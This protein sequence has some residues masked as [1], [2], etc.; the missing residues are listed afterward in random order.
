MIESRPDVLR[1]PRALLRPGADG[2]AAV[3]VWANG[4]RVERSVSVGLRG[5]VYTEIV[6]GLQEGEAVVGE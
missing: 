1:L 6:E 5:D 3:E 2:T 4:Q